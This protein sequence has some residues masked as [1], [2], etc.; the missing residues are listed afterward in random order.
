MVF[1]GWY[2]GKNADWSQLRLLITIGLACDVLLV[3][4]VAG[5]P[6]SPICRPAEPLSLWRMFATPLGDRQYR[7][8]LLYVGL[9]SLAFALSDTFRLPYLLQLGFG[10]N[11]SLISRGLSAAGAVTSVFIWGELS[12]RYGCRPVLILT[13]TTMMICTIS[14]I[15]VG[16]GVFGQVLVFVLFYLAGSAA[17]GHYLAMTR[18]MYQNLRPELDVSYIVVL[19]C[20]ASVGLALGGLLGGQVFRFDLTPILGQFGQN[21]KILHYHVLFML[22]TATMLIAMFV[23]RRLRNT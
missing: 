5:L 4:L 16:T 8:F 9:F 23:L 11:M 18:Y 14:L 6:K 17:F 19:T 12:D 10:Q 15:F 2:V 7:V 3:L 13:M 20:V 21:P 1:A 22:A